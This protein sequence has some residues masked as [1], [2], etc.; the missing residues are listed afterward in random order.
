MYPVLNMIERIGS[1]RRS[2]AASVDL[3]DQD[4]RHAAILTNMIESTCSKNKNRSLSAS[5][6]IGENKIKT[7]HKFIMTGRL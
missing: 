3:E 1:L 2:K 7:I 4:E 5:T 6:S